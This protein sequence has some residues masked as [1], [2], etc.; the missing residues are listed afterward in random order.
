MTL[1]LGH[2]IGTY[3]NGTSYVRVGTTV[4]ELT[5]PGWVQARLSGGPVE[6]GPRV[7]VPADRAAFAAAHRLVPLMARIGNIVRGRDETFLGR[8]GTPIVGVAATVAAVWFRSPA[9]ATL[10]QACAEVAAASS[11]P[12]ASVLDTVLD[13]LPT[14]L[15]ADAAH[16]DLRRPGP[17]P[18]RYTGP[19]LPVDGDGELFPIGHYGGVVVDPRTRN[20]AARSLRVGADEVFFLS[21]HDAAVWYMVHGV[22]TDRPTPTRRWLLDRAAAGE[23]PGAGPAQAA[24]ALDR[25]LAGGLVVGVRPGRADDFAHAFR[26]QYLHSGLDAGGPLC[27]LGVVGGP[28]V[29]TVDRADRD[30]W[31]H[32]WYDRSLRETAARLGAAEP[33]GAVRRLLATSA[34]YLDLAR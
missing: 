31:Q 6:D 29:A 21:E 4:H 19:A 13:A 30:L 25:L 23:L 10:A 9:T 7:D 16:L 8:F 12:A 28:V 27:E 2:L 18:P 15:T 17:A 33:L 34:A 3:P 14:L 5:T 32:G 11:T 24:A 22:G 1:T 26:L 20:P